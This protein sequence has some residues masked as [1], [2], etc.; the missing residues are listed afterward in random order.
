MS[1]GKIEVPYVDV[2][3]LN[4]VVHDEIIQEISNIIQSGSFILGEEVEKFE[5]TINSISQFLD[6][7]DED[8]KKELK[9]VNKIRE[10]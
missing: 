5:S 2:A 6:E 4:T 10:S 3:S 1:S 8:R 7:R 9:Y